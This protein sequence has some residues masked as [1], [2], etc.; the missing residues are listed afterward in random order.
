MTRLLKTRSLEGLDARARRALY[1]GQVGLSQSPELLELVRGVRGVVSGTID[2]EDLRRVHEGRTE[3]QVFE[4]LQAA[5]QRVREHEPRWRAHLARW[6][7]HA[8]APASHWLCDVVRLRAVTPRMHTLERAR[9]AFAVHRDTWYAN[10]QAQL[11]VW[12][13]L[14]DLEA[15]QSFAFYPDRMTEAIENDSGSF[16][17]DEFTAI[18]GFQGRS[19]GRAVYPR[20]LETSSLVAHRFRMCQGQA[21]VF[22]ASHLHGTAP[23]TSAHTRWSLD[24]RLVHRED[25]TEGRG[26]ANVDNQ[27]TGDAS[28]TYEA[29]SPRSDSEGSA[30]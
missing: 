24:V 10:P 25:M 19:G 2:C 28:S 20:A 4:L 11:N 23:N 5:R 29:L 15:S 9:A 6:L 13:P 1:D 8:G 27:S 3:A 18:A 14:F 12:L 22:S 16:D 17:F 21:L 7:T 30:G 26:A